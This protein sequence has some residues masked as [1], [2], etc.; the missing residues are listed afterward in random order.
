MTEPIPFKKTV[1]FDAETGQEFQPIRCMIC[2][3]EAVIIAGTSGKGWARLQRG[4]LTA[5]TTDG[6]VDYMEREDIKF[7]RHICPECW[8]T[9]KDLCAFFNRHDLRMR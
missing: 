9:D 4:A 7:E 5:I 3:A 6:V 2:N 1:T 8:L